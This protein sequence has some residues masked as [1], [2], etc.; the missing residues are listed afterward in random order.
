MTTSTEGYESNIKMDDNFV[1]KSLASIYNNKLKDVLTD[2]SSNY[3][4][5]KEKLFGKYLSEDIKF[6]VEL[7]QKR[8]RKQNKKLAENELCMARKADNAQC[9][10]RRKDSSEFCGKHC[11]NLKFGRIDDIEKYSNND[12]YI[13]CESKQIDGHEYLVDKST[14][15]VYTY[16]VDNPKIIGKLDSNSKLVLLS[17]MDLKS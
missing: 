5:N 14:N 9:T 4:I 2:I 10:R 8:K 3:S 1:I 11:N 13:K 7:F 15:I 6:N 12:D 16:D 17:E